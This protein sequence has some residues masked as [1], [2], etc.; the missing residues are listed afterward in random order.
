[1]KKI[2]FGLL[3]AGLLAVASPELISAGGD[4]ARG[5][6]GVGTV[7]QLQ[8]GEQTDVVF[9]CGGELVVTPSTE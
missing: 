4:K 5:C 1:M 2:I 7:A 3:V 6:E 9:E 8:V